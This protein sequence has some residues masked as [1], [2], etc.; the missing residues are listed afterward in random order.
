MDV[1]FLASTS[2]ASSAPDATVQWD[3]GPDVGKVFYTPDGMGLFYGEWDVN[4]VQ[5]QVDSPSNFNAFTTG[6]A[7]GNV[8]GP[9]PT[10]LGPNHLPVDVVGADANSVLDPGPNNSGLSAI[11][12]YAKVTLT[13]PNGNRGVS[14][15]QAGFIQN[16]NSIQMDGTY[17]Q[18]GPVLKSSLDGQATSLSPILDTSTT[19]PW[20]L[21][22]PTG[23]ANGN[24]QTIGTS[25]DTAG[26]AI[27]RERH[28][29]VKHG[30]AIRLRN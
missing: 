25:D 12:E 2:F 7:G 17:G 22:Q 18:N 29:S 4:V 8:V 27:Q 21:Y 5:V 13:G 24:V 11:F 15:M 28:S 14:R 19:G 20:Q 6:A 1:T 26:C 3:G 9:T 30:P 10:T 23:F 16:I